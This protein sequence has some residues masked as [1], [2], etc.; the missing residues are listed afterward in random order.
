MLWTAMTLRLICKETLK[1]AAIVDEIVAIII[2][3]LAV[4]VQSV[5][6]A[7]N[8]KENVIDVVSITAFVTECAIS[9][10]TIVAI[11]FAASN[12]VDL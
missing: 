10:G 8:A 3:A 7:P 9:V 2:N 11:S 4:D 1:A 6:G 5:E 12:V